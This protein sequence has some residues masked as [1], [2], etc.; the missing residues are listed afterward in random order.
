MEILFSMRA[1]F[2]ASFVGT[3]RA[4]RCLTLAMVISVLLC[5]RRRPLGEH[6]RAGSFS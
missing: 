4:W 1:S 6:A 2:V 5:L 3:G